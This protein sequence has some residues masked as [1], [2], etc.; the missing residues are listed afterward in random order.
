VAAKFTFYYQPPKIIRDDT[1]VEAPLP[2]QWRSLRLEDQ[3]GFSEDY[4]AANCSWSRQSV[5]R[6]SLT[7]TSWNQIAGLLR[8]LE[9]L[10]RAA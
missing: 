4:S 9:E 5:W 8:Q 6:V 2:D 7:F 1:P 3:F 10:R